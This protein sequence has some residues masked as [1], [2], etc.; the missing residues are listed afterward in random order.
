MSLQPGAPPVE[1]LSA[2]AG[3]LDDFDFRLHAARV[4]QAS[5]AWKGTYGRRSILFRT[6]RSAWW[7]VAGYL[8]GLSSPSVTLSSTARASSPRS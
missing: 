5:A 1:A 8:S 4:S 7:K 2:G 3:N 6:I